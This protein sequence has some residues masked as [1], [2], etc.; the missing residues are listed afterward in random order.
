M[1]RVFVEGAAHL[2]DREGE[3]LQLSS[4][5]ASGAAAI[6]AAYDAEQWEEYTPT[7][8][9]PEA[10]EPDWDGFNLAILANPEFNAAYAV[11]IAT[12]PLVAAALPAALTQVSS[13]SVTMFVVAFDALCQ[14]AQVSTEQR[15]AWADVAVSHNLPTDFVSSVRGSGG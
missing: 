1:I 10:L 14:A 15:T 13:G 7:E 11:A 2:V 5:S 12:F 3:E 4:Y 9:E 8:P 6:Q